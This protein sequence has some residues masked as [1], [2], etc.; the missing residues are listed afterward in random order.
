MNH[1]SE[2]PDSPSLKGEEII[3]ENRASDPVDSHV[4]EALEEPEGDV[5]KVGT[6]QEVFDRDEK[7]DFFELRKEVEPWLSALF[8]SE[9]LSLLTGSGLS[10]AVSNASEVDAVDMSAVEFGLELEEEVD[11]KA[12][13]LAEE[14][15]RQEAN[16]EHQLR[17]ASALLDGLETLGD[18]NLALDNTGT[19]EWREA[20]NNIL[21]GFARSVLG[22]EKDIRSATDDGE[23]TGADQL[24]SFLLSFS[25][26]LPSRDRL[27]IFTTNYDRVLEWGCD[28]AG[29]K[30]LD[31]FVGQVQ[32]RLRASRLNLDYHYNPP[33]IR[34]EPRYVEGVARLTKLH[35]SVDWVDTDGGVVRTPV[36][37]GPPDPPPQLP[38]NPLDALIVYPNASKDIDTAH[39]PYSELLRDFSA[40]ICR[41]NTA[42]VT[43][44]YG[45]GDSHINR[46]IG[47][48]LAIPSTH[49]VIISYSGA[50]GRIKDFVVDSGRESQISVIVGE[51]VA[52]LDSLVSHLL[53]KPAIDLA[54][55]RRA[56]LLRARGVEPALEERESEVRA[57]D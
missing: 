46:V 18:D 23:T 5:L 44:G 28:A 14:T 29:I 36:P 3:A 40:A 45:F 22:M 26:R 54:Q 24:V 55:K 12:Q 2:G 48:M 4:G 33:G 56:K 43:Y 31:Q 34:G 10:I 38:D 50:D 15:G 19:S 16:I 27:H 20:V 37:F 11:R 30:I 52:N 41:P 9:H 8:Q 51:R 21:R 39:F 35:G 13:S 57:Q 53:P 1:H 32:P 6:F 49:L 17:A 42:L 47:D 7:L 25:S